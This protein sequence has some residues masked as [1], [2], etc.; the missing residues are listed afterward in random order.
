MPSSN[1]ILPKQDN[2]LKLGKILTEA[3][4]ISCDQ[5]EVAL[6][7]QS[8]Y[9]EQRLGEILAM[10]GRIKQQTADFFVERW[11]EVVQEASQVHKRHLGEYLLE[12][13]LLSSEQIAEILEEQQ[14]SGLWQRFGAIA[15]F[16]GL[17]ALSTVEFFLS[18]LFPEYAKDSPFTKPKH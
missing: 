6:L 15:A 4:L 17:L 2:S 11:P 3:H 9:P 7:E 8:L 14:N 18:H 5:L 16:K 10:Q 12:A 1:L 13:G